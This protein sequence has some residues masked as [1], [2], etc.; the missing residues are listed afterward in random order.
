M[1]LPAYS[2]HPSK[3]LTK[4]LTG[5][6]IAFAAIWF[7]ADV[8]ARDTLVIGIRQYPPNFHPSIETTSAKSYVLGMVRRPLTAYDQNWKLV[9][10]LCDRLPTISPKLPMPLWL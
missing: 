6:L 2:G 10:M 3:T 7:P 4:I 5:L 1:P 8:W 9:C